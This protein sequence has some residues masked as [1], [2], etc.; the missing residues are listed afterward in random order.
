VGERGTLSPIQA[1]K[2]GDFSIATP[3][4]PINRGFLV[5]TRFSLTERLRGNIQIAATTTDTK[6]YKIN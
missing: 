1:A 3:K 5:A 6:G 2:D 4:C